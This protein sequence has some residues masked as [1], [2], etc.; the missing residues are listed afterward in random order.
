MGLS[1]GGIL[2]GAFITG[3]II[4]GINILEIGWLGC[5]TAGLLIEG[6]TITFIFKKGM[7]NTLEKINEG[8]INSIGKF[9]NK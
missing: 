2:G 6:G 5:L 3:L 1:A 8:K 7:K 4:P 9:E